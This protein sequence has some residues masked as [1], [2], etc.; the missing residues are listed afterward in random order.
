MVTTWI[1]SLLLIGLSGWMLDWH[2]RS[3]RKT[4]ADAS[5]SDIERRYALSQY[6]R[7]MQASSIIGVLGV[8]IALGPVVP[9]RPWPMMMYLIWVAGACLAIT[10]LAAIDAWAT[11]QYFA[12]LRSQN[13]AAQVQLS[14]ELRIEEARQQKSSAAERNLPSALRE[15]ESTRRC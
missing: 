8:A 1:V 6:R 15:G 10:F 14:R 13:L 11:R 2:R 9:R 12:R 5:I 4:E 7:R 3:W